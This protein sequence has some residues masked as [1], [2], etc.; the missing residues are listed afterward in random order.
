VTQR[1]F[2]RYSKQK[3]GKTPGEPYA[4]YSLTGQICPSKESNAGGSQYEVPCGWNHDHD[5]HYATVK[6]NEFGEY[7]PCP[8]RQ[9]PEAD[10]VVIFNPKQI[11]PRASLHFQ[12]RK[13][14]ILFVGQNC[15]SL[16]ESTSAVNLDSHR[17]T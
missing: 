10:E 13:K 6:K 1:P 7:A 14:T 17:Q 9:E 4:G 8:H 16:L 5:C 15:Q 2:R 3:D 12:R 11:L